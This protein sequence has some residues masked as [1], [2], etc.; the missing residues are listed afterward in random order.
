MEEEDKGGKGWEEEGREEGQVGGRE[1]LL[2]WNLFLS[3]FMPIP[4]PTSPF[5]NSSITHLSL[6]TASPPSTSLPHTQVFPPSCTT[7]IREEADLM[8][9]TYWSSE[10]QGP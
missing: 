8:S 10:R 2:G 3:V 4:P 7:K 6:F 5:C 9:S 1:D